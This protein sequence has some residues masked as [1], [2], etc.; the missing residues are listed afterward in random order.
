[1]RPSVELEG[2]ATVRAVV[3]DQPGRSIVHLYN[4]GVERISSFED[5]V[6]PATEVRLRVRTYL[7]EVKQASI[8]TADAAGTAGELPFTTAQDEGDRGAV[9]EMVVP[10]LDVSALVVIQ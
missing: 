7:P 5:K 10:R 6:T 4:L 3:Y 2:P 8:R 9:V 1:M